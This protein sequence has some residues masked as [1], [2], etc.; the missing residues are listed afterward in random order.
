MASVITQ[1]AGMNT[2]ELLST[3]KNILIAVLLQ[4]Y[5]PFVCG[6]G[7][8]LLGLQNLLDCPSVYRTSVI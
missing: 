2:E 1:R 6:I 5:S 3:K 7:E 4:F 8:N